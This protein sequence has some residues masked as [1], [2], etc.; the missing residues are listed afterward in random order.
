M[1]APAS[2]RS[3]HGSQEE[4]P[5]AIEAT[6]QKVASQ[7][8]NRADDPNWDGHNLGTFGCP[9]ELVE[10][11]GIEAGEG[12]GG[13]IGEEEENRAEPHPVVDQSLQPHFA[14]LVFCLLALVC[15]ESGNKHIAILL[16]EPPVLRW[17]MWD[18]D[19]N[20]DGENDRDE[21]LNYKDP[22]PAVKWSTEVHQSVCQKLDMI[23]VMKH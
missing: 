10:N 15:F 19:E 4:R 23:S 11:G 16:R 12:T 6:G 13:N 21:T 7:S 14:A 8:D 22:L 9:A 3:R 17:E 20:Q 18:E 5:A 2:G 1:D